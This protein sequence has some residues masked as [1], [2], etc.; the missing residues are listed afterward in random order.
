[1]IA[2][3]IMMDVELKHY[4][5]GKCKFILET[6][7]CGDLWESCMYDVMED[8]DNFDLALLHHPGELLKLF[9]EF[10]TDAYHSR[11]EFRMKD[12]QLLNVQITFNVASPW[13]YAESI[14]NLIRKVT[15]LKSF[16]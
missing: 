4:F 14:E 1:M 2:I 7:V 8:K 5:V 11:C 13:P 12:N 3:K 15:I 6:L 16:R 9:N 10:E